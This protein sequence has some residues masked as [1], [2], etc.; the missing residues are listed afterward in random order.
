MSACAADG[1]LTTPPITSAATADQTGTLLLRLLIMLYLLGGGA[2]PREMSPA[3][4][5]WGR[6]LTFVISGWLA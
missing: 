1:R 6:K 4:R 2:V 5:R 3:S